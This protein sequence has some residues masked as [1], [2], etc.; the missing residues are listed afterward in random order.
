MQLP[1][2]AA[3]LPTDAMLRHMLVIRGSRGGNWI[4]SWCDT[5]FG[6]RLLRSGA[7]AAAAAA[8]D[9]AAAA[10]ADAAAGLAR[11]LQSSSPKHIL[12]RLGYDTA[13]M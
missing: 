5:A 8:G 6:G 4:G 11:M 13:P 12:V 9:A 2:A 1:G 7:A 3:A 10:A